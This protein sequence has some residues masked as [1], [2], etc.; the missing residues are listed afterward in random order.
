MAVSI[1]PTQGGLPVLGIAIRATVVRVYDMR[2]FAALAVIAA[3]ATLVPMV[4]WASLASGSCCATKN[5]PPPAPMSCCTTTHCSMSDSAA[6]PFVPN[7][8]ETVPAAPKT[9]V[10]GPALLD[11]AVTSTSACA[12]D[13]LR[14]DEPARHAVPVDLRLAL[15]AT[16]LL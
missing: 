14:A 6:V 11:E 5:A 12:A 15:L 2:R 13:I 9:A 4:A 10:P 8:A 16:Y 3:I 1:L 7:E